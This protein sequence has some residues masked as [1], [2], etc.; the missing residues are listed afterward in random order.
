MWTRLVKLIPAAALGAVAFCSGAFSQTYSIQTVAGGGLP[1]NIPGTSA[2]LGHISGIAADKQGNVFITAPEYAAVLR[3]DPITKGLALVAGNGTLNASPGL[4]GDNGPAASAQLYGPSSVAVDSAGAVY[5]AD[6]KIGVRKVSGGA[7]TTLAGVSGPIVAADSLG[8][9]YVAGVNAIRKFS[10]GVVTAVAGNGTP[11]FSGDNGPATSAQLNGASGLAIDS[12]G[13][14]YVADTN[15]NVIRKVS[16]GIITTVAGKGTRGFSGDNGPATSAELNSPYGIAVDT[17][18]NLY[19]ADTNNN[20]IRKVSAGVITTV[21]GGGALHSS[22]ITSSSC[23]PWPDGLVPFSSVYYLSSPDGAGNRLLVGNTLQPNAPDPMATYKA[24]QNL[25]LPAFPDQLYCGSIQLAN[26]YTVQAYVPTAAEREGD[27]QGFAG[28]LLDPNS[29]APVIANFLPLSLLP[30][31]YPWRI[32][33]V[34]PG[35]NGPADSAVL[36]RPFSVAVDPSGNLYIADNDNARVRR[37]VNGVITTIAGNGT[38]CFNGDGGSATSARLYYPNGLAVD[39]AGNLYIADIPVVTGYGPYFSM[40]YSSVYYMFTNR[41]REVSNGVISTA[42]MSGPSS[43]S[44]D[45]Y[46]NSFAADSAGNLYIADQDGNVIH[47]VSNGAVTTVAG[48][49][50]ALDDGVAA[51]AAQLN[52]PSGMAVDSNGNLFIGDLYNYRVRKIAHG[53]ITTVAGNGTPG[54]SGDGG[55]ATNAQ[56]GEIQ[57]LAVD[58]I[59]NL[60]IAEGAELSVGC[61][62]TRVRKVVNGVITTVAGN[63]TAGYSGDNGPATSAAINA[64]T[65]AVDSAG[66]LFLA[67]DSRIRK[68]SGGVITTVAGNGTPGFGGDNGPAASAQVGAPNSLAVDA[69]GRVYI[70]DSDLNWIRM[71]TPQGPS[72]T[73]STSPASFSPPASGGSI[74][75]AV[76]SSCSWAVENLPSWITYAGNAVGSGSA[77]VALTI[78]ANPG[79][80][81]SAVISVAGVPILVTQASQPGVTTSISAVVNAASGLSGGIAPGEIVV[82]YG[83]GLGP[84]QLATATAGASGLFGTQLDGTSVSFNSMAAPMIY[85]STGQVAAVVPYGITGSTALVT[86]TYQGQTSAGFSVP[87]VP[88]APGIFTAGS[89]GKGQAAA[90]NQDGSLNSAANPAHLGD[91]ITLFAT[92]EGQTTPAGVDGKPGA[93]PLPQP[94]LGAQVYLGPDSQDAQSMQLQYAGGAPGEIAGLMQINAVIP[95]D[96][97]TGDA[98]PIFVSVGSGSSQLG[99]TIAVR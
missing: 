29:N 79:S 73:A 26:G 20:V 55:P 12:A 24:I 21:A 3:W 54:F 81:R 40:F 65:I 66:N 83:S 96:I 75:V 25:P 22:P 67:G 44:P 46:P 39:S 7:I 38:C 56:L 60:Y 43:L 30:M 58:A 64:T 97:Q 10:N 76:Q 6:N 47:E 57:A 63:G 52:T 27:F 93:V 37:V 41:V 90:I 62:Y 99:V 68:V 95:Q 77:S 9:L 78:A 72:C 80:G 59:G 34:D 17:A 15:N 98:V 87:I 70:S 50:S 84:A 45:T 89:T 1:V 4:P 2:S 94:I 8:N 31:I 69:K 49:G 28:T 88:S 91:V 51:T 19:I 14:L 36:D 71:L 86:I 53:V 11:G 85:T 61:C 23:A 16:A 42:A 35:D 13:N 48:G 74:T 5:I 82:I 92:G 33:P 32:A 18:G